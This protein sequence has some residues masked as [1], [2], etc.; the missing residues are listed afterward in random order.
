MFGRKKKLTAPPGAAP[1]KSR[2]W[3]WRRRR[4]WIWT[5][6]GVLV[7]LYACYEY[8]SDPVRLRKVAEAQLTKLLDASVH[9]GTAELT[10]LGNLTLR[11]VSVTL[12]PG[13]SPEDHVLTVRQLD[14]DVNL[15]SLL[16]AAPSRDVSAVRLNRIA[17]TGVRLNVCDNEDQRRWNVQRLLPRNPEAQTLPTTGQSPILGLQNLPPL[18]DVQ[19]N[20]IE[21]VF[22]HVR[23]GQYAE[24]AAIRLDGGLHPIGRSKC[25]FELLGRSAGNASARQLAVMSGVIDLKS[26]QVNAQLRQVDLD[27][28]M[29]RVLPRTVRR[30]CE[31]HQLRGAVRVPSLVYTPTPAGGYGFKVR[32]EFDKLGFLLQPRYWLS[33]QETHKLEM[34]QSSLQLFRLL[35]MNRWPTKATG[36]DQAPLV[37]V[38]MV[39]YLTQRLQSTPISLAGVAGAIVFTDQGIDIERLQGE[40]EGNELV[41]TGRLDGYDP[42][43][44]YTPDGPARLH[45]VSGPGK[46]L[47][48]PP[49]PGFMTWM[50][51]AVRD[52]YRQFVPVGYCRLDVE[53]TRPMAGADV[54]TAITVG[55]INTTFVYDE[56]PYPLEDCNG[57]FIFA[58]DPG[59]GVKMLTI[60][61]LRGHG[62]TGG[63]NEKS[64]IEVNGRIGPFIKHGIG[65]DVLVAGKS[66]SSEPPLRNAFPDDVKEAFEI[67]GPMDYGKRQ[68]QTGLKQPPL[69]IV[70]QIEWPRF[71]ADFTAHIKREEG[72]GNRTVTDLRIDVLHAWGALRTFP[73]PL[74]DIAA[75]LHILKGKLTLSNLRMNRNTSTLRMDGAVA[76]GDPAKPDLQVKATNVPID[77]DL[78]SAMPATERSWLEKSGLQ[79]QIDID[80]RVFFPEGQMSGG[81]DTDFDLGITLRDGSIGLKDPP[82]TINALT[83][84]FRLHPSRLELKQAI[85]RRGEAELHANGD[86]AW[87]EEAVS[88]QM[89][90]EAKNLLLDKPLYDLLPVDGQSAWRQQ[91]PEG[92]ADIILD[93]TGHLRPP[94]AATTTSTTGA[95]TTTSTAATTSAATTTRVATSQLTT[96]TAPSTVPTSPD[97]IRLELIPRE[98][99]ITPDVFPLRLTG[100][101]GKVVFTNGKVELQDLT[102]RR[103]D[104]RLRVSGSGQTGALSDF[105]LKI[106]AEALQLDKPFYKACPEAVA[107]ILTGLGATGLMDLHLTT[108][109]VR[110]TDP[111]RAPAFEPHRVMAAT[112]PTTRPVDLDFEGSITLAGTNFEVG[113]PISDTRGELT[114]KGSVVASRLSSFSSDAKLASYRI[115]G[116]AGGPLTAHAKKDPSLDRIYVEDIRT[117]LADGILAGAF[118]IDWYDRASSRYALDL[119]LKDASLKELM[120]G[121]QAFGE[122]RM[123]AS[124][125][126]EGELS[127]KGFRR[128][129]GYVR[130]DGKN[131]YKV[132]LLLGL[133]QIIDLSLSFPEPMNQVSTD[134]VLDNSKI[135]IENMEMRSPT[136]I[137]RATG[138]VDLGTRMFDLLLTTDSPKKLSIPIPGWDNLIADL[139]KELFQIRLQGSL[140]E[141]KVKALALPTLRATID[142]VFRPEKAPAK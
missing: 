2:W 105:T 6:V 54:E 4:I 90:V 132:P 106:D 123:S 125:R 55:I 22:S 86:I 35:D 65:V 80:G 32:V 78:L 15:P 70:E 59:T 118:T 100:L 29:L 103:G 48:I 31:E 30:W 116:M 8:V 121:E 39:N 113:L 60:D 53:V 96:S 104:T 25:S 24:N 124:L 41:V 47:R 74:E 3:F 115:S 129:G 9:V 111:G 51:E 120:S 138:T 72:A 85:G 27:Q 142:Q 58:P 5:I 38:R 79:G 135:R 139:K 130:V 42:L 56:F 67:F 131:M 40:F 16:R 63:S 73:Y 82:L 117:G 43:S 46:R 94:S 10:L 126:A 52:L 101:G 64:F 88:V 68:R 77:H 110:D 7:G 49:T 28:D 127:A 83:A 84:D 133:V 109:R 102:A 34:V 81:H 134:Y 91:Q 33:R 1:K 71:T 14:V 44:G 11:D 21:L 45:I 13:T 12:L 112:Q 108:L 97:N 140:Q 62:V 137:V 89:H 93:Y 76:F 75:G 61:H 17:A 26:G 92:S 136:T 128:G 57:R 66:I 23:G 95:T 37:P 99:A 119:L 107:N 69:T 114:L 87:P 19:F 98:L 18:P 36:G 122:G 50:P 141:P 20:D